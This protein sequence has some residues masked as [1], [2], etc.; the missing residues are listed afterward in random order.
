MKPLLA[1]MLALLLAPLAPAQAPD[2]TICVSGQAEIRVEPDEAVLILGSETQQME[3]A[4]S[5]AE[6][7]SINARV[8]EALAK[9]DIQPE[10]IRTNQLDAEPVWEYRNSQRVFEGY[11]LRR[12]IAVTIKAV[13]R[14]GAAVPAVLEA[15]ATHIHDLSFRTTELR[16]HRDEARRLA[17]RAAKEKADALAGELGISVGP[18]RSITER[19]FRFHGPYT[20]G[21][22]RWGGGGQM[23]MQNVMQEAPM[24]G[25]GDA[26]GGVALGQITIT[27]D[28]SVVFDLVV[29]AP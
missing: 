18:P 21:G 16:K 11:R 29:E 5:R 4:E 25:G 28:I 24:G 17:I 3:M 22:G 19:H 27:A 26:G 12:S 20:W 15:G 8:L 1:L 23:M 2:R 13:D 7:D 9:L 14:T 10:H 6:N